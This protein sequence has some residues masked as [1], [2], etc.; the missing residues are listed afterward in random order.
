MQRWEG[1]RFD[2]VW[3]GSLGFDAAGGAGD[4]GAEVRSSSG[5]PGVRPGS[6]WDLAGIWPGPGLALVDRRALRARQ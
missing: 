6:G 1:A 2:A 3:T 5:W 4:T